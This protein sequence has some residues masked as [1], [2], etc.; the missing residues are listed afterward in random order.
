MR[1]GR[2]SFRERSSKFHQMDTSRAEESRGR[3]GVRSMGTKIGYNGG[4]FR[5]G[6]GQ[7]GKQELHLEGVVGSHFVYTKSTQ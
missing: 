2:S 3:G 5:S 4:C 6:S 1:S 7:E